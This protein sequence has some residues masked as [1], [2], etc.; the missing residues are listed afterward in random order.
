MLQEEINQLKSQLDHHPEVTKY[1][2][3]NYVLKGTCV[4]HYILCILQCKS[5]I[6][7]YRLC[8]HLFFH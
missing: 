6:Y 8:I 4:I 7:H 1:A 5:C 3:E 2:M